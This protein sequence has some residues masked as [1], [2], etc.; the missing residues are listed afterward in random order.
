MRLGYLVP[1]F[2]S[3][4]HT[5]F[6]KEI[7]ELRRRGV[8]V[9]TV[10]TRRPSTDACRHEFAAKARAETK[11]LFPP[12]AASVSLWIGRGLPRASFASGY[13][14]S[15][16]GGAADRLR[17]AVYWACAIDLVRWADAK[18]LD[19]IHGHSCADSAHILA[20][21]R[22]LGGPPFSL[23]LHGEMDVYGS[24]HEAKFAGAS[25]VAAVGRHLCKE[26][27]EKTSLPAHK[28]RPTFMG[29][30]TSKLGSLARRVG[31]TDALKL[32]TVAR[33]HQNKGHFYALEAIRRARE[34]GLDVTYT[35]AGEGP[36]RDAIATRIAELNLGDA[37][38]LLGTVSE[39]EVAELLSEA[40]V[41]LLSSV[42]KGEAWPVAVMEAMGA[43][44]PVISSI[45]GATPEMITPGVDGFLVPQRDSEA[46]LDKIVV[47]AND[48]N[49]RDQ[50]GLAAKATAQKRF[51]VSASA[52]ELCRSIVAAAH[53]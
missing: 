1:E 22:H 33:L 23:T 30:D 13:L 7:C 37:V 10:S 34:I 50:I 38:N 8:E 2:P 26:I 47:L 41:F 5:F 39:E 21:S 3:Q 18:R 40:D 24:N 43:G 42:G 45:I 17:Q 16:G 19:H 6:W 49:L 28:V 14:K 32:L 44:L 51:D 52:E 25:F 15:L 53:G 36:F 4:T 12:S 20:L 48:I 9:F 35:I 29:I 31:R 46:I 11:Y 27:V